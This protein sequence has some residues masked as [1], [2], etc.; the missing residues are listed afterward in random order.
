MQVFLGI[1]QCTIEIFLATQIIFKECNN[2]KKPDTFYVL[3]EKFKKNIIGLLMIFI[4]GTPSGT[5]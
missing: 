4:S 3:E 5:K 2:L 1:C